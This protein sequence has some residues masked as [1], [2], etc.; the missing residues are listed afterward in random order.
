MSAVACVG[1][2]ELKGW[3]LRVIHCTEVMTGDPSASWML[4]RLPQTAIQEYLQGV[5]NWRI[6]E[7]MVEGGVEDEDSGEEGG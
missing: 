7:D 1:P 4:V 3:E 2:Q 6:E 5:R